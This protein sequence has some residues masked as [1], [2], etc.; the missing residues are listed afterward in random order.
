MS[1][2]SLWSVLGGPGEA[3]VKFGGFPSFGWEPT[4]GASPKK[5]VNV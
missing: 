5:V 4:L 1:S 2:F 3:C